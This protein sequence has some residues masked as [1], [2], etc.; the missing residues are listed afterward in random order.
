[1]E[2][3]LSMVSLTLTMPKHGIGEVDINVLWKE[4]V[5]F[6]IGEITAIPSK[7]ITTLDH[8]IACPHPMALRVHVVPPATP[9]E[10]I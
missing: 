5:V 8:A 7:S 3:V 1:M 6:G 9:G 10:A 2:I 4:S